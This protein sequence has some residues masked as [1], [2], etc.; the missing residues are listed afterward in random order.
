MCYK[1]VDARGDQWQNTF[2]IGVAG[3]GFDNTISVE[4]E[5]PLTDSAC[6]FCGNRIEVCP[7][8]ALSFRTEYDMREAGT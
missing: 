6:V 8:G 5:A 3:R 7:T 4:Q 2:A 1:S